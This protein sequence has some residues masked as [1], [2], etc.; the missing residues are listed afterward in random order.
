MNYETLDVRADGPVGWLVFDRP[1]AGNAIDARMFV[2]L[3][4]AWAELEADPG[5]RAIVNTGNGHSFQTGLDVKQLATDREALQ[6]SSR[7]TRDFALRMTAWHCGVTKPVV[8][9]VN[10]TCAG[11]GL[12]F[13]AD[14]DIVIAADDATFLDPH[15]SVGQVSAFEA[16]GL[17]KKAPMESVEPDGVDGRVRAAQRR[18]GPPAWHRLGGGGRRV[19]A[20]PRRG[21]CRPDGR[22]GSGPHALSEAGDVDCAGGTVSVNEQAYIHEFIDI[23]GTHRANY[24]HHMAANWS[25]GAQESRNQLLF[26]IWAVLGSTGPWPQVCNI[27]EEQ[28]LDGLARSFGGEAVGEGAARIQPWNGGGPR[29][30]S[31]VGAASTASCSPPRG[32][33]PSSSGW[34]PASGPA[35]SPTR[36]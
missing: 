17:L 13:V 34:P 14:A 36:S 22:R 6:A 28:G 29:R 20:G 1:D 33:R 3:E 10:G 2:E 5:V 12:H 30:P 23:R 18:A 24:M 26:G 32:C 4:A 31:S 25:P 19:S 15:V 16:I 11:G 8:A 21:A 27:W 7:Q 9:A 35:C